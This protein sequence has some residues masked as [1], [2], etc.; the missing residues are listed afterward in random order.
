MDLLRLN[1]RIGL[2]DFISP[3][4]TTKEC[5]RTLTGKTYAKI[6]F[7]DN[8]KIVF[9]IGANIGAAS[10][11]FANMY[12]DSIVYSFEPSTTTFSLLENNTKSFDSIQIYNFG[13]FNN[14]LESDIYIGT[15]SSL[16]NSLCRHT[17]SSAQKEKIQLKSASE[18]LS[19]NNISHIDILKIDTEGCEI[20]ILDS[21]KNYLNSVRAIYIEFHSE[22]D[23]LAIDA[24]L[25]S[26][27]SLIYGIVKNPHRG[28]FCYVSRSELAK[29]DIYNGIE[30]NINDT[31]TAQ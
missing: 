12:E 9:D 4:T 27:F 31:I 7:L 23:R 14:D 10:I 30:I 24:M 5:N 11:Y 1:T 22:D 16:N 15:H 3:K 17:Y 8:V 21:L 28:N 19:T 20:H 6:S 29:I 2:V 26:D 18:F 25:K 13:L